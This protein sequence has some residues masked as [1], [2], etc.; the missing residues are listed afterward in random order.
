MSASL[1]VENLAAGSIETGE[2]VI[3]D[4][5]LLSD[6]NIS[7]DNTTGVITIQEAGRYK[8]DWWV[9]TQTSLSTNGMGFAITSSQGD[10]IVGNS[11]IKTGEVVGVAILEVVTVPLTIEL[12]NNSNETIYYA[13]SVPVK[14]SLA[15]I[16]SED[17]VQTVAFGGLFADALQ[18]LDL[19]INGDEIQF[20]MNN[21]MPNQDVVYATNTVIVSTPGTYLISYGANMAPNVS[22]IDLTVAV[23]V[24]GVL[25][26][27]ATQFSTLDVDFETV[28]GNTVIAS[29]AAGAVLDLVAFS[30]DGG[31]VLTAQYASATLSVVLLLAA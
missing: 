16:G 6:G 10:V 18:T 3:F 25:L 28:Y 13:P 27:S 26:A 5:I 21:T 14:A 7:Y 22:E 30:V 11:P 12:K 20:E 17:T 4:S 8:F 19:P 1:Q 29:L 9:A 24:D 15:V 2:N 31:E 23:R